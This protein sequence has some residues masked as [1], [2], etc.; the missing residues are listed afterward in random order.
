[1]NELLPGNPRYQ[2]KEMIPVFGYDNLYKKFALVEIATL[3]TL[4]DIN[5]IPKKDIEKLDEA[6]KQRLLDI[7][8][9][10]VDEIERTITH[11]DIRAWV[12]RAQEILGPDLG[13]WVH[14]PLTSYD[15][16]DT[17]RILQFREAYECALKPSIIRIIEIFSKLV[18]DNIEKVQIG[19]THGQHAVPITV[20]FWLATILNR[21]VYNFERMDYYCNNLVGKISGPV[22][23]HNA[24]FGLQF[25]KVSDEDSFEKKVLKKLNLKPARIST[26]ILPPEPLGFFLFSC[27]NLSAVLGQFGRDSRHL[28]RSEIGEIVESFEKGQVGSSTMAHKRNPI[29]FE[30][31]EGMWLRTKSEFNK[32]LD[33]LISEHQRDLVGSSVARDYPIILINLQQQ[34]NTLL[35]KNKSATAF[36]ERVLVNEEAC[37]FN[38]RK[39]ADVILAEPL[40]I[41]L[42]MAGYDEDAHE[43]VNHKIIPKVKET[44]K[45]MVEILNELTQDDKKL[46]DIIKNIPDEVLGLLERSENYIGDAKNKAKEIVEYSKSIINLIK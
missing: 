31:I 14:I 41:A 8:T 34:L 10:E 29:N 15:V 19:R 40:Y 32:V 22:G 13:K 27:V 4:S 3:K 17:A 20:G 28:M 12:R 46:N 45:S 9:S 6:K 37:L 33:C 7:K 1:M 30:N 2:P 35:K 38:F 5:I 44:G 21:I 23:A 36:L 25:T 39:N 11:H 43:L 42:Q 26:Q 18:E 16:I 24:Q